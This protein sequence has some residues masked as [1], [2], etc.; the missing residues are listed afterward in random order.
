MYM[1]WL[2]D[3]FNPAPAHLTVRWYR[4]CFLSEGVEAWF[5][6]G[7]WSVDLA[8]GELAGHGWR[9]LSDWHPVELGHAAIVARHDADMG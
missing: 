8:D 1:A 5:V 6:P 3:D 4:G 2:S 7:P 9:R